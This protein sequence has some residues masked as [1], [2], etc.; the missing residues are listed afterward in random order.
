MDAGGRKDVDKEAPDAARSKNKAAQ[1][2][3]TV[4]VPCHSQEAQDQQRHG[5]SNA[6]RMIA[7]TKLVDLG[8]LKTSMHAS[9][10]AR[11][12]HGRLDGILLLLT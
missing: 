1:T 3:T 2:S 7:K 10:L 9:M 11:A 4:H 5:T 12:G 6:I 8:A